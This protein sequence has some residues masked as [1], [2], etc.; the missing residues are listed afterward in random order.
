MTGNEP[1]QI[2]PRTEHPDGLKHREIRDAFDPVAT[3]AANDAAAKY[4]Q[5]QQKWSQGLETFRQ[6]MMNS[7]AEAWEGQAAEASKKAIVNYTIKADELTGTFGTMA[8]LVTSTAQSAVEVQ[9]SLPTYEEDPRWYNPNAWPFLRSRFETRRNDA[10]ESARQIMRD[11]YVKDF[12]AADNSLP[13]LPR[14]VH[15]V[16]SSGIP[17]GPGEQPIGQGV[18]P[19]AGA[20]DNGQPTSLGP[21]TDDQAGQ[22][23]APGTDEPHA[24][25][26]PNAA[27]ATT[28]A[29]TDPTSTIAPNT[30]SPGIPTTTTIPATTTH[31]SP[32]IATG[33]PTG[34]PVQS[35]APGRSILGNPSAAG[36]PP[37]TPMSGGVG[38]TRGVSGMPGMMAPGGGR[39]KSEDQSEHQTADYLKT[40]E[41][42]RE[43][44]G[45]T[46]RFLPGGV[47][48]ARFPS[49]HVQTPA[50]PP[51]IGS[52]D[53]ADSRN[54]R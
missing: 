32:N 34:S 3:T 13:V 15:L 17:S 25:P 40:E 48:G 28:P 4:R 18:D 47:L 7:I 19:P 14:P 29:S 23:D 44:L 41:N 33:G 9:R 46:P 53:T 51:P 22:P 26:A 24:T 20:A 21:T 10:E 42:T 27:N 12:A 5:A 8:Q 49:A 31:A 16:Q 35:P 39:G 30:A 11:H 43:L 1:S 6:R 45:E 54:D 2:P 38:P 52:E 50:T 36:V 37:R